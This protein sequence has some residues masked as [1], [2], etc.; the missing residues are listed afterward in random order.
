MDVR[1]SY[2]SLREELLDRHSPHGAVL[3]S[4]FLAGLA[5]PLTAVAIV[6]ALLLLSLVLRSFSDGGG[7][8][9][10]VRASFPLALL[11]LGIHLY[12]GVAGALA[13]EA[14]R[15]GDIVK[16]QGTTVRSVAFVLLSVPGA[17]VIW[18]W[19]SGGQGAIGDN[20]P[21]IGFIA[22]LLAL[23]ASLVWRGHYMDLL[24]T[25][26]PVRWA[27]AAIRMLRE[28]YYDDWMR[29][30]EKVTRFKRETQ[31]VRSGEWDAFIQLE[32]EERRLLAV[33][34][35]ERERE[36]RALLRPDL[37][38]QDLPRPL[39]RWDDATVAP[40]RRGRRTDRGRRSL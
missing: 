35:R 34:E 26:S 30:H 15:L 31:F 19:M 25:I 27:E 23:V 36:V 18:S 37:Y 2:R 5:I 29:Y 20:G 13:A 9:L 11:V 10:A 14:W 32:R 6:L 3:V 28:D 33:E 21:L 17:V 16:Q 39:P 40:G 8:A 4:G 7:A 24:D 38:P 12:C 1:D 22:L